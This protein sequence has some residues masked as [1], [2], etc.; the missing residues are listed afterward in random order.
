MIV[1]IYIYL[2]NIIINFEK[3]IIIIDNIYNIMENIKNNSY[4]W[5][6]KLLLFSLLLLTFLLI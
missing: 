3:I 5:L 1:Y 2:Q 4:S 6:I